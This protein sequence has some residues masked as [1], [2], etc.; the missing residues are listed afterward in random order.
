MNKFI[1]LLS[2]LLS[3]SAFAA[4]TVHTEKF[5][6]TFIYTSNYY[7]GA[8]VVETWSRTVRDV[9]EF[10]TV[11]YAEIVELT[12]KEA[13]GNFGYKYQLRFGRIETNREIIHTSASISLGS[14]GEGFIFLQYLHDRHVNAIAFPTKYWEPIAIGV[15]EVMVGKINDRYEFKID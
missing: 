9:Q 7:T 11:N 5:K 13:R 14:V 10:T 1:T 6:K 8:L 3:F 2:L 4:K 15:K 12:P